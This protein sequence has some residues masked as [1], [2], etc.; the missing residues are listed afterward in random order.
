MKP[1]GPS[2]EQLMIR[3]AQGSD[4]AVW[5]LVDRYSANI[6]RAVRRRLSDDLRRKVDS[7]DIVQ[8][9]WKSLLRKDAGMDRISTADEFVAFIVEVARRKTAETERFYK[10]T[11]ARDTKREVAYNE[12][13]ASAPGAKE[14][15]HESPA[16]PDA[17]TDTPSTIVEA[18]ENWE[19]CLQASGDRARQIVELRLQQVS[20]DEIAKRLKISPSTVRR[21]VSSLLKTLGA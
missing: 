12:W 3:I 10:R 11:L 14:K 6:V 18:K 15:L 2:F 19:L 5:E 1:R 9:V 13:T 16:P 8:S 4:S 7:V 17:R 21:T 20:D